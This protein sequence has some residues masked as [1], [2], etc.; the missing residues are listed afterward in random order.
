MGLKFLSVHDRYL[1]LNLKKNNAKC[2]LSESYILAPYRRVARREKGR[3]V[4][5]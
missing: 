4:D 3:E 2:I 1:F 5:G